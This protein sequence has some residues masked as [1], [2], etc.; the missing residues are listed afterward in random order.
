[1]VKDEVA[2]MVAKEYGV[3]TLFFNTDQIDFKDK[4]IHGLAFQ[5]GEWRNKVSYYPDVVYNDIPLRKDEGIYNQ[6]EKEGMPFT[7]HRLGSDKLSL[8]QKFSQDTVLSAFSIETV[9]YNSE[10]HFFSFLKE[11]KKIFLMPNR[12]HK[13]LGIY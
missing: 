11:H 3:D 12:G 2:A 5:N 6:L 8:Q 4:L 10:E 1:M 13:G 9:P 7:T